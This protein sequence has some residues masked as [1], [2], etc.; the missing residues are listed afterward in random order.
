MLLLTGLDRF[1]FKLRDRSRGR[2]R[3]SGS[4]FSGCC[5]LFWSP[6]R[7]VKESVLLWRL[8]DGTLGLRPCSGS[9]ILSNRDSRSCGTHCRDRLCAGKEGRH[10]RRPSWICRDACRFCNTELAIGY[11]FVSDERFFFVFALTHLDL[12]TGS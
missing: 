10:K 9:P 6:Y 7:W 11:V 5:F 8:R 2:S 1:R 12:R 4:R 3:F